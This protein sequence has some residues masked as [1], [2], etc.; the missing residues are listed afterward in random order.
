MTCYQYYQ[1]IIIPI[2]LK[3]YNMISFSIIIK[4]SHPE[5]VNHF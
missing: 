2:R 4:I 5:V 3:N 1:D